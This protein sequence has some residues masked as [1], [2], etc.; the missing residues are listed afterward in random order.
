MKRCSQ[1]NW[2][3]PSVGYVVLGSKGQLRLLLTGSH[4]GTVCLYCFVFMHL[5]SLTHAQ[6][7]GF[8]RWKHQETSGTCLHF[9][10]LHYLRS[11]SP[12]MNISKHTH[13]LVGIFVK[14]V[15]ATWLQILLFSLFNT[16]F[17]VSFFSPKKY[18]CF[19]WSMCIRPGPK[20]NAVLHIC[21][22]PR[23]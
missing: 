12:R 14:Q 10:N 17:H 6:N 15:F 3:I 13:R 1:A 4:Y 16:S 7:P 9:K 5:N 18:A 19:A 2:F 11:R 8:I 21:R 20:A 22:I 23:D